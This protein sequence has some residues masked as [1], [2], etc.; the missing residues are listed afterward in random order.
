[1]ASNLRQRV[2]SLYKRLLRT[3]QKWEAK[4]PEETNLERKYI[5]E[6]TIRLFR[7]N[8]YVDNEDKILEHIKEGEARLEIGMNLFFSIHFKNFNKVAL[9][10]KYH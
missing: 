4:N 8:Q 5:K 10:Q 2:L 3:G 1:M 9:V 7:E 6:E